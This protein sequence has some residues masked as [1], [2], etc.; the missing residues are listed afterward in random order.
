[1][2]KSLFAALGNTS[3]YV[4]TQT[5]VT[6]QLTPIMTVNPDDGVGLRILNA[7]QQGEKTGLPIYAIL[8]D[9]NGDPLPIDTEVAIGYERPTDDTFQVVSDPIQSISTYVKKSIT[10]QQDADNID[11]VKHALRG[12]ALEVRDIDEMFI[13]VKSDTEVDHSYTELYV[14]QSA[15]EEVDTE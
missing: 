8:Q 10:Q 6:G 1:M 4:T 2:S 3:D 7:V 12:P 11:S 15:V 14:E 13:L 9:A 5:N